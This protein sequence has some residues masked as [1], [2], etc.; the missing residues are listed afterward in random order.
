MSSLIC[1]NA[2][3]AL[4]GIGV[5]LCDIPGTA[6]AVLQIFQQKF[7]NPPSPLDGVMVYQLSEMIVAGAV[8]IDLFFFIL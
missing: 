7:A 3:N 6:D 2:I 1:Q 4:G 5:W 8:S